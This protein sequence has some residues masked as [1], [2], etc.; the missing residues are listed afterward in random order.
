MLSADISCL[1]ITGGHIMPYKDLS[2]YSASIQINVEEYE[3]IEQITGI[4]NVIG[5]CGIYDIL[6]VKQ[7]YKDTINYRPHGMLMNEYIEIY[8]ISCVLI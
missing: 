8:F 7:R 5:C 1:G 4:I 2:I 3:N 6:Q